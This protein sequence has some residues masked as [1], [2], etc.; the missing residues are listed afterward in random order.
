MSLKVR[1]IIGKAVETK[2]QLRVA[3]R[4]KVG[5]I[6]AATRKYQRAAGKSEVLAAPDHEGFGSGIALAEQ[7]HCGGWYAGHCAS[8]GQVQFSADRFLVIGRF[9]WWNCVVLAR[10]GGAGGG[11]ATGV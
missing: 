11:E 1:V 6:D 9:G 7:D 10:S 5:I 8:L 4:A 2:G 3:R